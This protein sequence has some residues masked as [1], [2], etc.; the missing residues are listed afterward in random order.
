MRE[1]GRDITLADLHEVQ[2]L[3]AQMPPEERYGVEPWI[4]EGL[5]QT[6]NAPGYE[7]D[8]PPVEDIP[9]PYD[10]AAKFVQRKG[11]RLRSKHLPEL[12]DI[13]RRVGPELH[14]EIMERVRWITGDPRYRGDIPPL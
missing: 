9:D 14:C 5:F 10:E 11:L 13:L 4:Y 8:C 1:A 7:G 6:V 12:D 2:R 3:L